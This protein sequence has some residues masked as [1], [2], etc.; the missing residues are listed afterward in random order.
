MKKV[1]FIVGVALMLGV[2]VMSCKKDCYCDTTY[3]HTD[4]TPNVEVNNLNVGPATKQ[5]CEALSK[6]TAYVIYQTQ[7][8]RQ[9]KCHH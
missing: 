9:I 8:I 3:V 5:D 2:C 7:S 1:F 4:G 6:D